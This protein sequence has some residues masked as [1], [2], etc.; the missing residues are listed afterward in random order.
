MQR[1]AGG[2][3]RS[4][5]WADVTLEEWLGA[6]QPQTVTPDPYLE[7]H[8]PA[9]AV[10]QGAHARHQVTL[11]P[12]LESGVV[13]GVVWVKDLLLWE[14]RKGKDRSREEAVTM[15]LG[16][17]PKPPAAENAKPGPPRHPQPSPSHRS[18]SCRLTRR[19]DLHGHGV[20][21]LQEIWVLPHQLQL[22]AQRQGRILQGWRMG[23][24]SPAS[25][26][27]LVRVCPSQHQPNS[28]SPLALLRMSCHSPHQVPALSSPPRRL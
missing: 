2:V 25:H 15:V 27:S 24:K 7:P 5:R 22:L 19:N 13:I 23:G 4:R 9:V 16:C 26:P 3:S 21:E 10:T 28:P 18:L 6:T 20:A 17:P 14:G 8:G 1:K 11:Q 12:V